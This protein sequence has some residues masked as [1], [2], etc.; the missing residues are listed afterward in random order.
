VPLIACAA[1]VDS[2]RAGKVDSPG[3]SIHISP[4]DFTVSYQDFTD[5]G[6]RQLQQELARQGIVVLPVAARRI[7][8]TVMY[9]DSIRSAGSFGCVID[10]RVQTGDGALRGLQAR[11]WSWSLA[12]ACNAATAMLTAET[13]RDPW[14]RNYLIGQP[15]PVPH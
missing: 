9:V 13:L 2:V 6:V 3:R 7:E 4:F 5:E 11:E 15:R 12:T 10:Y 14:V 8:L 1:R